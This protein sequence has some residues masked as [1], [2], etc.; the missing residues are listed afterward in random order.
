MYMTFADELWPP[1]TSPRRG[2]H[3]LKLSGQ[4]AWLDEFSGQEIVLGDYGDCFDGRFKRCGNVFEDMR[5]LGVDLTDSVYCPVVSRVS[6]YGHMPRQVLT[7]HDVAVTSS[8]GERMV[9]HQP[10]ALSLPND[11]EFKSLLKAISNRLASKHLVRMVI[12]CSQFY[13][14]GDSGIQMGMESAPKGS[15]R[16]ADPGTFTPLCFIARPLVWH[17]PACAQRR[18]QF[19]IIEEHFYTIA[20]LHHTTRT[21]AR[22][23]S[24]V[25]WTSG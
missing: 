18:Q 14:V 15:D 2:S 13:K 19:K 24:A 9:L 1:W 20:N 7:R 6:H 8:S 22:H 17:K 12:Q 16:S 5:Q 11:I 21:D 4:H 23:E 3:G 10:K 25:R